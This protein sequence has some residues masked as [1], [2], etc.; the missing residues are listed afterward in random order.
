MTTFYIIKWYY[1]TDINHNE[2][3]YEEHTNIQIIEIRYNIIKYLIHYGI[4][5]NIPTDIRIK[6]DI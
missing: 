2:L 6:L 3:Q 5:N 1:S 4:T